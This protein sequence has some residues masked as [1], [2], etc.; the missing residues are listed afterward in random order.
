MEQ[1]VTAIRALQRCVPKATVIL[2][3]HPSQGLSPISVLRARFPQ[4]DMEVDVQSDIMEVLEASDLCVGATSAATFQAAIAGTPVIVLNLAD[5]E[6]SW[7]LGE[8]T[9]VPV[10]RN[11]DEL[12]AWIDRWRA[13]EALPGREDLLAGLGVDGGDPTER[14]LEVLDGDYEDAGASRSHP[15][16]LRA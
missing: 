8:G 10:A 15:R 12:A 5:F 16:A 3:P 1:Y 6:W 14:L 2:R 4:V 9:T 7:P 13:G 11:E